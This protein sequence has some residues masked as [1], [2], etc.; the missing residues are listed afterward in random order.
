[1]YDKCKDACKERSCLRWSVATSSF[2]RTVVDERDAGC[3]DT[4]DPNVTLSAPVWLARCLWG[5]AGA[6]LVLVTRGKRGR[7]S[8]ALLP[9]WQSWSSL[10]VPQSFC[11][12][13]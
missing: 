13:P 5:R 8:G 9:P 12:L 4:K 10:C 11:F 2:V 1:M 7:L 3:R 6:H